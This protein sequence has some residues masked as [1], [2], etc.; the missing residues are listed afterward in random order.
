MNSPHV[1]PRRVIQPVLSERSMGPRL[2][3]M[4]VALLLLVLFGGF[5]LLWQTRGEQRAVGTLTPAQRTAVFQEALGRYKV[6]CKDGGTPAVRAECTEQARYLR[7]FP[8]CDGACKDLTD[9]DVPAP[10]R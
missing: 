8:E 2:G 1:S 3:R 7:L 5:F 6:L 9:A 10:A 4:G